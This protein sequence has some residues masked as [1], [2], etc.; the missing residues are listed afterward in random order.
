MARVNEITK[1]QARRT[2]MYQCI[3]MDLV[4]MGVVNKD[5]FE[6]M[7]GKPLGG[8]DGTQRAMQDVLGF[9]RTK[10]ISEDVA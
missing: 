3:M 1:R 5:Q 7:C 6:A 2:K 8:Y 10:S 4:S 9:E